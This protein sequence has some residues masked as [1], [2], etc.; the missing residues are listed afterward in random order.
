VMHGRQQARRS[1][2]GCWPV[3]GDKKLQ[4]EFHAKV[5]EWVRGL[6]ETGQLGPNAAA[7]AASSS[8]AAN[9]TDTSSH[10]ASAAAV[11][12][13]LRQASGPRVV[14][15]LCEL[16]TAALRAEHARRFPGDAPRLAQPSSGGDA[17]L[18]HA[19]QRDP[20]LA[21]AAS[22]PLLT[23]A[24]QAVAREAEALLAQARDAEAL[25][26]AA[27][28]GAAELRDRFYSLTAAERRLRAAVAEAGLTLPAGMEA[29]ARQDQEDEAAEEAEEELAGGDAYGYGEEEEEGG[30]SLRDQARRRRAAGIGVA[31]DL[32]AILAADCGGGGGGEQEG[33][34]SAML[35]EAAERRAAD[36]WRALE[37]QLPGLSALGPLMSSV[38]GA[39]VN[40][41]AAALAEHPHAVDG[42]E[43]RR[44]MSA[45]AAAAAA[46]AGAGASLS[47]SNGSKQHHHDE[48]QQQVDVVAM[49]EAWV[50]GIERLGG[51]VRQLAGELP[52][53]GG[54]PARVT[55]LVAAGGAASS[56]S[57]SSSSSH[58]LHLRAAISAHAA[59]LTELRALR[60]RVGQRLADASAAAPEL[61]RRADEGVVAEERRWR[62]E[63]RE[64]AETASA[65]NAVAYSVMLG[66]SDDD[67]G[68][69]GSAAVAA[70]AAA[71]A[72]SDE[73]VRR[74]AGGALAPLQLVPPTPALMRLA[75][76]HALEA[77]DKQG[78]YGGAAREAVKAAAIAEEEEEEEDDEGTAAA[79]G[80]LAATPAAIDEAEG[81]ALPAFPPEESGAPVLPRRLSY[82]Q[83][84]QQQQPG[85]EQQQPDALRP[86]AAGEW[87]SSGG[88][89][90]GATATT[91]HQQQEKPSGSQL[92]LLRARFARV[93]DEN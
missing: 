88:G 27:G 61:R 50:E 53:S 46:E 19:M 14:A 42:A 17:L 29:A 87:T 69:D 48:Q 93:A 36:A 33:G 59:G 3:A 22:A 39:E 8:S 77:E 18:Q 25:R 11:S 4:K 83:Q 56:S 47:S 31:M 2:K 57:S 20:Y 89:G 58:A 26:R 82:A 51:R 1:F 23:A 74:R 76:E 16:S 41:P 5:Q 75:R 60:A 91:Q 15:L 37:A 43:L 73:G 79:A 52:G 72:R 30:G 67:G 63:A 38:L 71:A 62:R 84:Q 92:H 6:R 70:A 13:A 80:R 24:R 65:A 45:A 7:A 9:T 28:R 78:A 55:P 85:E 49:L 86:D 12:S 54:A 34:R 32:E 90:G 40:G 35:S 44:L 64:A 21:A 81:L 68:G 66:P 10:P